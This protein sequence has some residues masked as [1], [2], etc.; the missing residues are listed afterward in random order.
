M[1][2]TGEKAAKDEDMKYL[3][4]KINIDAPVKTIL[5]DIELTIYNFQKLKKNHKKLYLNLDRIGKDM[6]IFELHYYEGKNIE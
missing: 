1:T 3:E 6:D 5:A 2:E 4:F